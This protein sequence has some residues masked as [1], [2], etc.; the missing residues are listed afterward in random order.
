MRIAVATAILLLP[1]AAGAQAPEGVPTR[2]RG[3]VEG[4]DGSTLVVRTRAGESVAAGLGP[5]FMVSAVVRKDLSEIRPGD[6]VA[7]TSVRG[8]NGQLRALEVHF[9]PAGARQGQFPYDL[10]PESVMTNALVSG[11]TASTDGRTL[12]VTFNGT[13]TD[14]LVPTEAPVVA[15]VPADPSLI[16]PGAAIV[17]SAT[18]RPDGTL[19]AT[20]ATVEKDGVKPP[21]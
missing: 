4:F 15:F 14:V 21:M 13:A 6:L 9:L 18:A 5:A 2:I 11:I 12:H 3:T 20:R 1:L 17:L 10:E 19:T 7:S 16:R 8:P